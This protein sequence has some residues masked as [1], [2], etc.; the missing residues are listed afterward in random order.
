MGD[1]LK[2]AAP[3]SKNGFEIAILCALPKERA[4]VLLLLDD[5]WDGRGSDRHRY[6]RAQ[7]DCNIYTHGRIGRFHVVIV[8]LDTM[9]KV[10]AAGAATAIRIGY[11]NISLAL[12]VGIC[13]GVPF[14]KKS[15]E[16][17]LGD[18]IISNI[19]IHRDFGRQ[20]S[21]HFKAKVE[22]EH[23]YGRPNKNIRSLLRSLGDDGCPEVEEQAAKYLRQL[24]EKDDT[25]PKRETGKYKYPGVDK[26]KL[27]DDAYEH[28]HHDPTLDCG[29]YTQ[30]SICERSREIECDELGC[31]SNWLVPRQ[32][33][34]RHRAQGSSPLPQIHIGRMGSGDSVIRSAQ[35]RNALAAEE[36]I[37]IEMEGAGAWDELPSIVIKGVCD[38]ADSHKSKMWQDYAAATAA[39]V[40]KAVLDEY[41]GSGRTKGGHYRVKFSLRGMPISNNFV[42]RPSDITD[43]EKS[44]LPCHQ[45]KQGCNVFVLH[46]LGGIGKTQLAVNFARQYKA[47]FS[48]IF[49]LDGT[50]EDS[51][52]QSFAS[53]AKR[54]PKDQI[55]ENIRSPKTG[56]E[57]DL[58]DIAEHV[59]EWL[60]K[61]D[62]V[63]WLLI[64]DNV[65]LDHTQGEI[66][67]AYDIRKYLPSDH[68]AVLITSRLSKLA[69]LGESK[70]I[71]SADPDLS[72]KIFE[73]W[74]GKELSELLH[75]LGGLPLVLAQAAAYMG[76]LNLHVASYIRLYEQQWDELF[77][78]TDSSLPDYGNRSV[79]TTWTISF[80]AIE[81]RDKNAGNLLRLWAFLDNREM[82]HSLLQVAINDQELWPKWLRD[83]ACNEVKFFNILRLLLRYSMIE[84]R[85]SEQSNY[86]MHPVVHRWISH[87]QDDSRKRVFLRLAVMLIGFSVPH[88]TTKNY[89]VLQRR[90]LPHAERCL[91]WMGKLE[92][93]EC[94][95]EDITMGHA[96]NSLG[97]LYSDHGRLR[98]LNNVSASARRLREGGRT[99]SY[100]DSRYS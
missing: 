91:R 2:Y 32:R 40:A 6:A 33:L 14:P 34:T 38:Y 69:Q 47:A 67:G 96:T 45:K 12:I 39:L 70:R 16:V 63:D 99:G 20:H 72:K 35:H 17:I 28:K 82:W 11:P 90:L 54:I 48:A 74:Y 62:N 73:K 100:V 79:W 95:M 85:E 94:N 57:V 1:D 22:A 75:L 60:A 80:N 66:P 31:D 30:G 93:G 8:L 3:A 27:F 50:S 42:P 92:G 86:S 36:V 24:Q 83:I 55:P 13:A 97:N 64:F 46:G 37:G 19:L 7:G 18:I 44:L 9:G 51:L 41:L 81:T 98:R 59:Q 77:Q 21:D 88:I 5:L 61:D 29:C 26:D 49:W 58:N 65:D 87:I 23:V 78:N 4:A 84:A 89:W 52:K 43:I 53:C 68:G 56:D 15:Q 76:E 25:D 10:P 71:E